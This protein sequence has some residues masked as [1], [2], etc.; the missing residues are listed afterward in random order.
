M[1][2]DRWMVNPPVGMADILAQYGRFLAPDYRM[3]FESLYIPSIFEDDLTPTDRRFVIIGGDENPLLLAR[4]VFLCA[5]L[6]GAE[7]IDIKSSH[8]D[9]II[10][11]DDILNNHADGIE[12]HSHMSLF[13]G[14]HYSKKWSEALNNATDIVVFGD[15]NTLRYY[16]SYESP[17]RKVWEY[18]NSFSFGI[19]KAEEINHTMSLG[20]CADFVHYYGHGRLAPKFYFVIGKLTKKII[21]MISGAMVTMFR[22]SVEEY[23]EKL[24]LTKKSNLTEKYINSHYGS[25]YVRINKL[26]DEDLFS[27]LFGDVRLV[28][29]DSM[30]EIQEF[31]EQYQDQIS[32]VAVSY[33]ETN[34]EMFEDICDMMVARVCDIGD[35]Q[36]PDFFEQY[37]LIDDFTIYVRDEEEL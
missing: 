17:S 20:I 32:T 11:A 8:I 2:I 16:R 12:H 33:D 29:V 14:V 24:P 5:R 9:D 6:S 3:L 36:F 37:D 22:D 30:D 7:S 34:D 27:P 13:E 31:M 28:Q 19:V 15:D 4:S 26:D 25:F 35:M 18:T 10:L 1:S 21:H 23:R